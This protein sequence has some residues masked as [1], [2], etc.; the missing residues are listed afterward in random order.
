MREAAIYVNTDG[1]NRGF[2]NMG[3]SHS[4]EAVI[5]GVA[6]DVTIRRGREQSS[7]GWSGAAVGGDA[8][9]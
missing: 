5:N 6:R 8:E 4:L 2:L 7:S 9:A 3:G 1:N